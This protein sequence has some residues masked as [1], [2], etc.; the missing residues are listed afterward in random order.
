MKI[1]LLFT[2]LLFTYFISD[3]QN[4]TIPDSN[5]EQALIDLGYDSGVIDGVVPTA[6]INSV[7]NLN[8]ENKNIAVLTGIEDFEALTNLDCSNN[9]LSNLDLSENTSLIVLDSNNNNL[10]SL[11]VSKSTSLVT[12]HCYNNQLPIL[13]VTQ[14]TLLTSLRANDNNLANLDVSKNTVLYE[15]YCDSNMLTS[16]D[17]T[18]NTELF[19]LVCRNNQLTNLDI[20]QN[21]QLNLLWAHFNQLTGLD[22]SQNTALTWLEAG[23]NQL[24]DL[25]VNQNSILNRLRVDNNELSSLNVKNGN[26][27]NFL[28]FS[29]LNNINLNCIK[30]DNTAYSNANWPNIDTQ[31]AFSENC[32]TLNTEDFEL[33]GFSVYPNPSKGKFTISSINNKASYS[34]LNINGQVLQ[35]GNLKYGDNN[36]EII[37][38][39]EGL[40]F[41]RVK[42]DKGFS[43]KKLIKH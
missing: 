14:N 39:S 20:S 5:F 42:T 22:V 6:N 34:L 37:N 4:T 26:N 3:S 7:T 21:T 40:Y 17:V 12:L 41:L 33:L 32:G 11:E 27:T 25:D 19:T 8:L 9:L 23:N 18:N 10:T 43:A 30:V 1:K 35:K 16:I 28:I 31:T 36:L 2:F 38:L 29:A 15:L 13:D 24:T